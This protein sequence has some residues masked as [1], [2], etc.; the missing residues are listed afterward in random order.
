MISV[1]LSSQN[2]SNAVFIFTTILSG[3]ASFFF[4][5]FVIAAF[6]FAFK[7][8]WPSKLFICCLLPHIFH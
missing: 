4:V 1:S 3:S 7:I 5:H 8:F 6:T 2:S